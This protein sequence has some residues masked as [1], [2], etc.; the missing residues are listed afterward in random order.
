MDEEGVKKYIFRQR[1]ILQGQKQWLRTDRHSLV[2]S[3]EA[4][5]SGSML[6]AVVGHVSELI[7][8]FGPGKILL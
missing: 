8:T 3:H 7:D 5:H 4:L 1:I 2:S 6:G